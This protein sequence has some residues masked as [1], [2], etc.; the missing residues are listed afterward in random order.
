M[1]N[2]QHGL[3]LEDPEVS[4]EKKI[5]PLDVCCDSRADAG[6]VNMGILLADQG[7]RR[8]T[9]KDYREARNPAPL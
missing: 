6:G 7:L 1:H 9:V 2:R 8:G 3:V 5:W 4:R